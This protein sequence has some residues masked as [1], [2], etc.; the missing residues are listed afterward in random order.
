MSLS[1]VVITTGDGLIPNAGHL[2]GRNANNQTHETENHREPRMNIKDSLTR[3]GAALPQPTGEILGE[4]SKNGLSANGRLSYNSPMTMVSVEIPEE[5][6]SL[7]GLDDQPPSGGASK[8]LALELFREGRISLGR[9]SELAG[10]GVEEFMEFSAHREVPL[11]YTQ[12]DLT[13]DRETAKRLK[14]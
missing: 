7:A 5:V 14:L 6:L 1:A 4:I 13:D 8:L 3:P 2:G 10:V 12:A 9:A 11:H